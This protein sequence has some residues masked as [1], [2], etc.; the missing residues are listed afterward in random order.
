VSTAFVGSLRTGRA[1]I[2]VASGPN[3]ITIRVEA[4]D[5]WETVRVTA[6]P[7]TPVSEVKQRV[8]AELFPAGE[9]ADDF[10]AKLRGWEVLDPRASLSDA[11]AVDGSILLL[12]YRRRRP[13]R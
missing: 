11:G 13:V 5:L 1:P 6:L 9:P 8:V 7:S 4:A 12:H 2:F 3:A 10:V